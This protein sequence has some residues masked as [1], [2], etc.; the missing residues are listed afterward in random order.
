MKLKDLVENSISVPVTQKPRQ[1]PL[2][3][4]TGAGKH[5]DKKK[6]QKQGKEKHKKPFTEQG[7]AEVHDWGN[8]SKS[9]FKRREMEHE[10]GHEVNPPRQQPRGMYFYNV[11]KMDLFKA[12]AMG[13]RQSRSGKWYSTRPNP[14]ADKE[15]GPGRY[16]EPK[17][18]SVAGPKS[19]WPGH[20]KVGT[21]P[22][23][24]KN[25]GKRV[26]KCKKIGEEISI[27]SADDFSDFVNL[28]DFMIKK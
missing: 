10:L 23:T 17:T 4:Q 11:P 13:L 27:N 15:Y 12:K 16:W 18:E 19:C 6:D 1:G 22:G 26:N 28:L 9:E 5:K 14:Q 7:V 2:R 25:A 8:M 21:Q 20:R 24:G 3:P